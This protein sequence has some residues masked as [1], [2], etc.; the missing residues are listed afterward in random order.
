MLKTLIIATVLLPT[1]ALA[2][3]S[4]QLAQPRQPGQWC[5]V[6]WMASGMP[7]ARAAVI[8]SAEVRGLRTQQSW[9]QFG[10]RLAIAGRR[11]A[12]G[13]HRAF[14]RLAR[15][16]HVPAHH[17]RELAVMARPRPVPPKR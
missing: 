12:H 16:G 6:G 3:R 10:A 2:Q 1:L 5:P 15:H 11:Q 9:R 14:A 8:A 4:Q 13:E 7:G 17:A